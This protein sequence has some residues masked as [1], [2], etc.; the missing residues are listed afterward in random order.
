MLVVALSS[1]WTRE[2]LYSLI[3]ISYFTDEVAVGKET[4]R[5][6]TP[7]EFDNPTLPLVAVCPGY[8]DTCPVALKPWFRRL[9]NL[10]FIFCGGGG[11]ETQG[12]MTLGNRER[13]IKCRDGKE[14]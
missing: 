6:K 11:R 14:G 7:C 12:R 13:G 3:G 10:W 9:R 1:D 5:S 8:P 4:H 2:L